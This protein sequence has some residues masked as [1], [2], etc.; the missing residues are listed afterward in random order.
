MYILCLATGG[1]RPPE[2]LLA[3]MEQA[4]IAQSIIM[5]YGEILPEDTMLLDYTIACVQKYPQR[6]LGFARMHPGGG[7]RGIELFA[8]A[9]SRGEIKGLKFHPV[10]SMVHPAAAAS[11]R[12][13]EKAMELGVPVLFH[14]GDEE[15]TLPRQIA[16]LLEQLPRATIIL[17]HMGGYFHSADAIAVAADYEN[18]YLETS[19]MPDPR[20]IERAIDRV[21]PGKIIFGS[22]GP[23]CV[24]ALEVQKIRLIRLDTAIEAQIF[25]GNISR[26]I[27]E[28]GK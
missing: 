2:R 9:V 24:P 15:L 27:G 23:G 16:R 25:H 7:E 10:G 8:R 13:T 21:G 12:F 22:D 28:N 17:G 3:L 26:L 4:D 19:A 6:L 5:P 20:V 14:C 11:V 18:C 1:T